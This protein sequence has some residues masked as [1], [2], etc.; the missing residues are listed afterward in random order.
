M[1]VL[2]R[3]QRWES[4]L[5]SER[6][7]TSLLRKDRKE[8]LGKYRLVRLTSITVKVMEQIILETI[9]SCKKVIVYSQH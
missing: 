1:L 7:Q 6:K 9:S 2:E 3:S 5:W 8:N 4:F